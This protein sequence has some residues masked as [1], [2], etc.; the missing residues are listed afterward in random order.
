VLATSTSERRRKG[1]PFP[2]CSCTAVAPAGDCCRCGCLARSGWR[3]H[4]FCFHLP[5]LHFI[6]ISGKGYSNLRLHILK[7]SLRPDHLSH[8][9]CDMGSHGC[10]VRPP[11]LLPRCSC[12]SLMLH[13]IFFLSLA[14]A[15]TPVSGCFAP[16]V[17]TSH[18]QNVIKNNAPPCFLVLQS[19]AVWEHPVPACPATATFRTSWPRRA[20]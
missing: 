5:L 18:R 3:K 4:L 7:S 20:P 10:L 17:R 9:L 8:F 14:T 6:C 19:T 13:F 2:P 12:V 15:L 16:Y 11:A 1:P